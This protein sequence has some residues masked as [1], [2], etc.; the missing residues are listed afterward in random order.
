MKKGKVTLDEIF[1][2]AIG[3]NGNKLFADFAIVCPVIV[4]KAKESI[5]LDITGWVHSIGEA[6]IRHMIKNHGDEISETKRGQRA[7]TKKE[8][9]RL[10][11]I[12]T[13]FDDIQYTGTN[14]SGNKTFL[15]RKQI[16]DEIFCVQEVRMGRKKLVSKTMW[17]RRKKP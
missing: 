11:E 1:D 9:E 15:I 12:L 16:D 13:K 8:I 17:I 6:D 10:P 7:I 3:G 2:L 14:E 5:G 4:E